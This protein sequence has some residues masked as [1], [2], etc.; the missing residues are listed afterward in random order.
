MRALWNAIEKITVLDPTCGSGAFLFAAVDILDPLYEACLDRMKAFVEDA[1]RSGGEGQ[2]EKFTD[3]RRVLKRVAAHPNRRYFVYKSIILNNLFGVDIME[4]AVE[5]CK[6]RLFLKLAAQVDPDGTH[7]NLGIEPLPDIDFNIR[8]GNTLVG[9]AT[10][11]AVKSAV[12]SKLD[13][14]N[15]MEKISTKAADLQQLFDAFRARQVEGAGSVSALD[16][17]E[18][19]LQ[20]KALDDE[21][22]RYLSGEYEVASAKKHAFAR[23]LKS[24]Q[25]FHWFVEFYGI[26]SNGGFDVIVG[27]PPYVEYSKVRKHYRIKGMA[28]ISCGNLYALMIERAYEILSE[29]GRFGFIVQAPLVSTQRMVAVRSLLMRQSCVALFSTFD[30][31]PSKLFT[32][33]HHCRLAIILSQRSNVPA[34][35]AGT[36]RYYKWRAEER[37]R[38]L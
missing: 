31:R 20:L 5:I 9:Y 34:A 29:G 22:N 13:F 3:F 17:Q 10:Y 32:G 12:K 26:M 14:D 35:W 36:T 4:A 16:K 37:D 8:A 28:T 6:I 30:D 11:E 19:R 18:L 7:D 25:P 2:Q 15:A 33:I 21:L 27:N 1:E 38:P 24:H 23:W